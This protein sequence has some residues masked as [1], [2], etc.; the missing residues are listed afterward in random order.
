MADGRPDGA[1]SRDGRV[2]G[3]YVHGLF[4]R[5]EARRALLA[6]LGAASNGRDRSADV[7][8]G[9]A[10]TPAGAAALAASLDIDAFARIA[11]L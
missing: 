1:V 9:L 4:D 5:G 6:E 2:A 10:C 7:D 11:G 3:G 8:A